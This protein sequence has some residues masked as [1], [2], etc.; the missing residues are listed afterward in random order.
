MKKSAIVGL[1]LVFGAVAFGTSAQAINCYTYS[2]GS[3]ERAD[4]EEQELRIE[5]MKKQQ[6]L[7]KTQQELMKKQKEYYERCR[8]DPEAC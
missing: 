1:C 4:C 2:Y 6:E 3:Q 7:M 5:T 8:L